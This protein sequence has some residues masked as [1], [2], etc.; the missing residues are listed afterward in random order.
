METNPPTN[1]NDCQQRLLALEKVFST[2]EHRAQRL[3]HDNQSLQQELH[4]LQ[5]DYESLRVQKGGFGFKALFGSG[6]MA[7]LVAIAFG[8]FLFRPSKD[9]HAQL[10]EHLQKDH[11]FNIEYAIGQGQFIQ[12]EEMLKSSLEKPENAPIYPE[13]QMIYKI[14][15]AAKRKCE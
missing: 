3:M 1:L 6:F 9:L 4:Q 2:S 14:V 11:Q 12:A 7:T 15:S 8:Y 5:K 13:I 10:F